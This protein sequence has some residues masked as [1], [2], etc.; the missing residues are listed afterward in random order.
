MG[1]ET[2]RAKG[3]GTPGEGPIEGEERE[4]GSQVTGEGASQ[5]R[6]AGDTLTEVNRLLSL[7]RR[8][9]LP[10]CMSPPSVS[11]PPGSLS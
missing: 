11:A 5:V 1:L 9:S 6:A 7:T 10:V 4:K 8:D 2:P 3:R